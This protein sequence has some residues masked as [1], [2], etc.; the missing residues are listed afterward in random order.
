ML[1]STKIQSVRHE[2]L[3]FFRADPVA[4][5]IIFVANATAAVK[6]V[7]QSFRDLTDYSTDSSNGNSSFWFGYHRDCHTS[8][9]G[10]RES[11][12]AHHRCFYS[13][14]DVEGWLDADESSQEIV[15]DLPHRAQLGLFAYPGQSNMTGRRLPLHW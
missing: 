13:D 10:V 3:A 1:S 7:M 14:K 2:V 9:V 6:L 8:L 12:R 4:F 15:S 11:T 5:D